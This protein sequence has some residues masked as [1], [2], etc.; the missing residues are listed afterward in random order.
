[1]IQVRSTR[2]IQVLVAILKCPALHHMYESVIQSLLSIGIKGFTTLLELCSEATSEFDS[3][4]LTHIANH[5][6]VQQYVIIPAIIRECNSLELDRRT[7]AIK[8]FIKLGE[9]AVGALTTL[10]NV[11]MSGSISRKLVVEAIKSCGHEGEQMLLF[12]T[13][14]R[15]PRVRSC[16]AYILGQ[17][18]QTS[19]SLS[20]VVNTDFSAS[21]SPKLIF[22]FNSSAGDYIVFDARELLSM[23][24]RGLMEGWFNRIGQE[25]YS[26]EGRITECLIHS[27]STKRHTCHS[28]NSSV[29]GFSFTDTSLDMIKM[30]MSAG[31]LGKELNHS[32]IVTGMNVSQVE[33]STITETTRINILSE[34]C[35]AA[36]AN[37]LCD[38]DE[39]VRISAA[40]SLGLI[41]L[42]DANN[43]IP[44]LKDSLKDPSNKVRGACA[45]AFGNLNRNVLGTPSKEV[46]LVIRSVIPL[47]KD[48]HWNVRSATVSALI[49]L[50]RLV[51]EDKE[52]TK[53]AITLLMKLL[54]DGSVSRN[55]VAQCLMSI[56]NK[57]VAQVITILRQESHTTA[58][59]RISAAYGL[60]LADVNS[61]IIDSIVECLFSSAKDR[62]PLVRRSVIA[63]LGTL[64]Q[65]S[66]N[67][68]TYLRPRSLLPF[69][70]SFLKDKEKCVRE[71]A[72]EVIAY[73][74]PHGELLLIEGVL[75][76]SNT[77][78]RCSAAYGLKH[79]GPRTI[80]TLLLALNDR[81][82][83]VVKAVTQSIESIGVT[84][85]VEALKGRP[86]HQLASIV[87]SAREILQSPIPI[88][89]TL[90]NILHRV[91]QDLSSNNLL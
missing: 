87:T 14:N 24:N 17:H 66:S 74:G 62:N 6:L 11:L 59:M 28:I 44:A 90:S 80:R 60:S 83:S 42:P 37:L 27:L 4:I 54:K 1:M 35:S 29:M 8:A 58:Q 81:D 71:I 36:L 64:A 86:D 73:S 65:R 78:I 82:I 63:A 26:I 89:P 40:L 30:N 18:V 48:S 49:N 23:I 69:L 52:S 15:N 55:E 70:Y 2:V 47:L 25:L 3:F 68:V 32:T 67:G 43:A 45:Q 57:G 5:P 88:S 21:L 46:I 91:I 33:M 34:A 13:Q 12:L 75:K 20:V 31:R 38:S 19:C 22:E 72:A 76:D 50:G 84:S 77:S 56:G 10:L 7:N 16:V 41:G 53:V 9:R 61:P 39:D 85:F 79:V 51:S